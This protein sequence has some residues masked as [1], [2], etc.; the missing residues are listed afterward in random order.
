VL[1]ALYLAF[2]RITLV[3]AALWPTLLGLFAALAMAARTLGALNLNTAFL[4]SI[5]LGNGINAPIVLIAE[6]RRT[7]RERRAFPRALSRAIL[8]SFRGVLAAMLSAAA[9]YGV[10]GATRFRGFRQFGLI[11]GIGMIAVLFATYLALPPLLLVV[12]AYAPRLLRAGRDR[13]SPP[14]LRGLSWLMP[15]RAR[16]IALVMSAIAVAGTVRFAGAPVEWDLSHLRSR[17]GEAT[18]LWPTMEAL[19]MG[20]VGAGYIANT[21]VLL[22]EDPAR[23][24]AVAAA[25]RAQDA[26]GP[27]LLADVR[28]LSSLLPR[29]QAEKLEILSRLRKR[30]DDALHRHA[31]V[32]SPDEQ[33]RLREARPPESLRAIDADDLPRIVREAFTEVDGTRGRLIG[34]DADRHRYHDWE[35]HTLLALAQVLRVDEGGRHYVAASAA[36]V[37]AGMLETLLHDAPRLS[38]LALGVVCVL[39][40]ITMRA[41]SPYALSALLLGLLFMTGA[42]GLLGLRLNFMSF[43][44]IPISIGVGADYAANLWSRVRGRT[45]AQI[46]AVAATVALCS[47]TT[48]IGYSSL[49]L[50]RNGALR[51]FGLLCDV[52]ELS[53][54]AAVLLSPLLFSRR[55]S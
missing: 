35:G 37:F 52:G 29:E 48:I 2:G 42:T 11:G 26:A 6:L 36:T 32:L 44:A 18:R 5:I 38:A 47:L 54:I 22:V 53:C 30:I 51:S 19:G 14:I 40:V 16:Y 41:R 55:Q 49:L 15:R 33:H 25:L 8:R 27:K 20:S 1:A 45:S 21:G 50:G 31:D 3:A 43:A 10:L 4:I 9:A 24:D 12:H 34:I 28:T 46:P 23:A 7:Q 13:F 17:E 39:L